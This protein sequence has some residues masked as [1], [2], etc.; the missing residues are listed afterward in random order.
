M[1]CRSLLDNIIDELWKYID[2]GRGDELF[3]MPSF[4]RDK[5]FEENAIVNVRELK[6]I[7]CLYR[8]G[9]RPDRSRRYTYLLYE[10][11]MGYSLIRVYGAADD[12]ERLPPLLD[13]DCVK[14]Y[15]KLVDHYT[16]T[17]D[18]AQLEHC[19]YISKGCYH[20]V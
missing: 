14:S 8:E 6:N 12:A 4:L 1:S 15:V 13:V 10:S 18:S 9:G 3:Y 2:L 20:L 17:T 16:F 19:K 11:V 7:S 5:I